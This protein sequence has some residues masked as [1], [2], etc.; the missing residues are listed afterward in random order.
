MEDC[1]RR[2]VLGTVRVAGGDA[3]SAVR[4]GAD[5]GLVGFGPR[6]TLN[7][8]TGAFGSC[9]GRSQHKLVPAAAILPGRCAKPFSR[10]VVGCF[11]DCVE[12]HWGEGQA[13][14]GCFWR[15]LWAAMR[16]FAREECWHI[17]FQSVAAASRRGF[18]R[19]ASSSNTLGWSGSEGT[20]CPF[21]SAADA[22]VAFATGDLVSGRGTGP[23]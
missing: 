15:A 2:A 22:R 18:R 9:S 16:K 12:N 14:L 19:A 13:L 20:S 6:H 5:E 23:A 1:C 4:G 7:A 3:C 10:A 17:W 21:V 8:T 11:V